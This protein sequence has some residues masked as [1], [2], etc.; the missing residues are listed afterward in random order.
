MIILH[1]YLQPQFKYELFDNYIQI[2][3]ISLLTEDMKSIN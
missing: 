3:I 1:F 2:H